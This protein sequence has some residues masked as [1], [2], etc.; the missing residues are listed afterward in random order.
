M[1]VVKVFEIISESEKGGPEA[2]QEGVRYTAKTIRNIKSV[3]LSISQ[4]Y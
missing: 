1:A 4:N 3:Y 2:A